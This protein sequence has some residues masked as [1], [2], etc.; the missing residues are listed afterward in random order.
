MTMSHVRASAPRTPVV[1]AV[2]SSAALARVPAADLA[3]VGRAMDAPGGAARPPLANAFGGPQLARAGLGIGGGIALGAE[4]IKFTVEGG[5]EFPEL[6]AAYLVFVAKLGASGEVVIKKN[7]KSEDPTNGAK[8]SRGKGARGGG[9]EKEIPLWE[10]PVKEALQKKGAEK[11][12]DY[13]VP[14]DATLVVGG[15][16]GTTSD[17]AG[18][19]GSIG[20]K[21]KTKSGDEWTVKVQILELKESGMDGPAVKGE[22]AKKLPWVI[23]NEPISIGGESG[24]MSAKIDI[25]PELLVKP[26]YVKIGAKLLE[27]AL[28]RVGLAAGTAAIPFAAAA[29]LV[30]GAYVAE[31]NAQ[32]AAAG[33]SAGVKGKEQLRK[34]SASF[35]TG[36]LSGKAAGGGGDVGAQAADASVKAIKDAAKAPAPIADE[37]LAKKI[38][39]VRGSPDKV[40]REQRAAL[41]DGVFKALCAEFD[42]TYE[43]SFWELDETWGGRGVFRTNCRIVLYGDD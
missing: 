22:Y 30:Y 24:V 37:T 27:S 41:R 28:G 13:F 9:V 1:P 34:A 10:S 32:A 18:A 6:K 33:A 8:G 36:L 21:C 29:V 42:K 16:G 38:Q 2:P 40:A 26:D 11:W 3:L 5:F 15:E 19:S 7:A 25:K 23:D 35:G 20:I 43:P 31:R 39:E 17:G 4:S 14:V 12:Q